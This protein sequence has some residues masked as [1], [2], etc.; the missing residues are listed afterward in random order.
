MASRE[1]LGMRE[2]LRGGRR[3]VEDSARETW[4]ETHET[5]DLRSKSTW[6]RKQAEFENSLDETSR[7]EL[8]CPVEELAGADETRTRRRYDRRGGA[9][10][11]R[12]CATRLNRW[13]R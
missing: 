7:K 3:R 6:W 4:Q 10:L 5:A 1:C 8:N 9:G 12:G 13:E 2:A 11:Q